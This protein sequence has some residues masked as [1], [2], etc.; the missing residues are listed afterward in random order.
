M[1]GYY[2]LKQFKNSFN[3]HTSLG[4][5]LC[6]TDDA[7]ITNLSHWRLTNLKPITCHTNYHPSLIRRNH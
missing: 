4:Q 7:D 2:Y 3:V 6:I 1:Q 5:L